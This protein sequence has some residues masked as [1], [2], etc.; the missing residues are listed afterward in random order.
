MPP[1][2]VSELNKFQFEAQFD[3]EN[4]DEGKKLLQKVR[5]EGETKFRAAIVKVYKNL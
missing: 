3:H 1:G 4:I 5:K 2:F